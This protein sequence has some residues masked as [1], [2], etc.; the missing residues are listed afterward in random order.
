MEKIFVLALCVVL[1]FI[2]CSQQTDGLQD[3][4][5]LSLR[6]KLPD[7][8]AQPVPITVKH[9]QLVKPAGPCQ[10]SFVAHDL[11]HTTMVAGDVVRQYD[12]NGAG[13]AINDLDN[14][15]DLD[16]VLA[17]L[18]GPNSIFWNEG[19]LSFRRGVLSHGDSRAVNILDVNG[20]GWQDIV[21]SRRG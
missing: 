6:L 21:F 5:T 11:D 4:E 7:P 19:K 17:N 3:S 18:D 2:G 12:S 8:P 13:L 20:D 14:D 16:I 10:N 1:L 15:G 9:T